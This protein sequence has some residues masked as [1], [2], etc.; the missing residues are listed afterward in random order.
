MA[1]VDVINK[2]IDIPSGVSVQFSENRLTVKGPKGELKRNFFHP[3]VSMKVDGGKVVVHADKP[4]R[5]EMGL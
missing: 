1:K 2:E 5:A 4:K 3:R